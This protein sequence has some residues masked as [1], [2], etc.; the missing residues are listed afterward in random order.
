[1]KKMIVLA[2]AAAMAWAFSSCDDNTEHCWEVSA[3]VSAM[4]VKASSPMGY[5]WGTKKQV[6]DA[7]PNGSGFGSS[8]KI[9]YK[10]VADKNCEN[11]DADGW[12]Y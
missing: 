8:V 4:G 11:K 6:K 3:E 10:Q 7:A 1:M 12:A 2:A 9:T 5:F